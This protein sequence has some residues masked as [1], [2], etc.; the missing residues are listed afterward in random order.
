MKKTSGQ[1]EPGYNDP[2][3]GTIV[4]ML[5]LLSR[6]QH[7][8]EKNLKKV[9]IQQTLSLRIVACLRSCGSHKGTEVSCF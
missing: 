2:L 7:Y 3:T 4:A 6:A 5:R 1:L 9:P 8:E